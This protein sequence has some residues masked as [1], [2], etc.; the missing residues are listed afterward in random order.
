MH[1]ITHKAQRRRP[2]RIVFPEGE[3]ETIVR[4]AHALVEAHIARP[5]LL[6]RPDV[7]TEKATSFGITEAQFD[8]VD[9]EGSPSRMRYAD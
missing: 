4:A 8:V 2:Q 3:D 6:G 5:I 9:V 1:L 7:V